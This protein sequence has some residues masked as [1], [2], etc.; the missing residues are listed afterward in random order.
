MFRPAGCSDEDDSD[1]DYEGFCF[2]SSVRIFSKNL[3]LQVNILIWCQVPRRNYSTIHEVDPLQKFLDTLVK[4]I[5]SGFTE[6][7]KKE[8]ENNQF[9][10]D[11]NDQ[12]K[13]DWNLLFHACFEAKK[14]IV[15]YLVE[16][17]AAKVNIQI[18]S[19][20][21]LMI[22]CSSTA[23]PDRV[24][25]VVDYLIKKESI[26]NVSNTYGMTP[27]MFAAQKGHLKVVQL[28]IK[29]GVSLEAIENYGSDALLLAIENKH[30]EIAKLLIKAGSNLNIINKRGYNAKKL[31]EVNENF[32]LLE[33]FPKEVVVYEVPQQY[34]NYQSIFDMVPSLSTNNM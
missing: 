19:N 15:E 33:L 24:F 25:E 22:A 12:I 8:L 13:Y 4:L 16:E 18:N 34:L 6:D 3:T 27:L 26:L 17:K 9:R 14:E 23:D 32:E 7:F 1:D 5:Q 28:F 29:M 21:P 2:G 20:T 30:T 10:Y 11:V 31:A